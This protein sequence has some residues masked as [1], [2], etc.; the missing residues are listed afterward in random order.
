MIR[1]YIHAIIIIVLL[2]GVSSCKM[3][4]DYVR[5]EHLSAD[6]CL[7]FATDSTTYAD[8]PWWEVYTDTL[9]ID[10]I[11]TALKNNKDINIATERIHEYMALRRMTVSKLF[12]TLG[13]NI[14][15]GGVSNKNSE[16]V[17]VSK[18]EFEAKATIAWEV[19][20]WGKLRRQKEAATADLIG[21]IENKHTVEMFLI[22]QVAEQYFEIVALNS[23]LNIVK[24]TI[25]ARK[26]ASRIA[27]LRFK[28]GLT[29]EIAYRQAQVE[30][31]ETQVILPAVEQDIVFRN[32]ALSFLLGSTSAPMITSS[33]LE[34][35]SLPD[36]IPAGLPSTLINR[37]PD[38][39]ESEQALIAA[40]ANVGIAK[41]EFFPSLSLTGS[42]GFESPDLSNFFRTPIWGHAA[43]LLS[44]VFQYGKNK[45]RFEAAKAVREQK[46]LAYQ[47]SVL[48]GFREVSDGVTRFQKSK[49][50]RKLNEELEISARNY[51]KLAKLQYINGVVAYIDV[52]DA[53]RKLFE[54]EIDLNT[55]VR[56][57]YLS[58]VSLYKALGGGWS[59]ANL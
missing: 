57:E 26:E 55:S 50:I 5:S 53:Q 10:L 58:L 42:L 11:N 51:L 21:I 41:A 16:G 47:K 45:G 38:I 52:L 30:L 54:A 23:K 6:S 40:N 36:Y 15:Y 12:P 39:R 31:A 14:E 24:Q 1:K 49:V 7:Q 27:L 34:A 19:D 20:I 3:G 32:N 29:S 17:R 37:R 35:N 59:L 9:L 4:K 48:N 25:D 8:M 22:A 2:S 46:V 33:K 28:G 44:P 18:N 43:N 56:N 13:A